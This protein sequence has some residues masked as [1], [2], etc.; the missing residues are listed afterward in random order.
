MVSER[1]VRPAHLIAALLPIFYGGMI[2]VALI[3]TVQWLIITGIFLV[4][5][6]LVI[7]S[8]DYPLTAIWPILLSGFLFSAAS[9]A[10]YQGIPAPGPLTQTRA[11]LVAVYLL[12]CLYLVWGA[13]AI[14]NA[15]SVL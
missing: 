1:L 3:N 11:E 5:V 15:R 10:L 6:L 8:L 7:S 14:R 9:L 2:Y 12:A 13:R 4:V